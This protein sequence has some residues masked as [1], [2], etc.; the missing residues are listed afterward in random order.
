[1]TLLSPYRRF[2][3][4]AFTPLLLAQP[5]ISAITATFIE[6]GDDVRVSFSGTIDLSGAPGTDSSR[7]TI[8]VFV[9]V[10]SDRVATRG[11]G[12]IDQDA[13]FAASLPFSSLSNYIQSPT[14]STFGFSGPRL[15]WDDRHVSGGMTGTVTSLTADPALDFFTLPGQSLASINAELGDIAEGATL[16]T[17]NGTAADTFIFSRLASTIPEPSA[18]LL[19]GLA[20]LGLLRRCR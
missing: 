17:S 3:L 8:S 15:F 13:G 1:M 6:V 2:C 14:L 9:P 4:L 20:L 19:S 7:G 18:G 5:A 12:Y 11:T 10:T 16:W